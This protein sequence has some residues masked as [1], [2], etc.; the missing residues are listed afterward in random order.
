MDPTKAR[1]GDEP[2]VGDIVSAEMDES[3]PVQVNFT[4]EAAADRRGLQP[5]SAASPNTGADRGIRATGVDTAV[6]YRVT[7]GQN[8]VPV[9][10]IPNSSSTSANKSSDWRV[11]AQVYY[12]MSL[13]SV[14]NDLDETFW[15]YLIVYLITT[16]TST[17]QSPASSAL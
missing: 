15:P 7:G 2:T 14:V 1:M 3:E 5:D 6:A 12:S 8:P 9:L 11:G 10:V 17:V 13:I 4:K 16:A